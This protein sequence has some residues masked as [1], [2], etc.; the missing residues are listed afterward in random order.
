MMSALDP[1]TLPD[2]DLAAHIVLR[3]RSEEYLETA[4]DACR[5]LYLRHARGLLAFLAARV[6]SADLEDRHQAIW[7]RVWQR[8]P[9]SFRGGNFRAWLY[10]VARNYVI[11]QGQKRH[12]ESL[13]DENL[14]DRRHDLPD[15]ALLERERQLVLAR[16]LEKLEGTLAEL[17]RARLAGESYDALCQRLGLAPERAHKL[18]HQ[19]KAQLRTCVE[20]GL[21]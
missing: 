19:A 9:D 7:E 20:G 12:A 2:E 15:E 14:P 17:V 5:Q 3:G 8:L 11:D 1:G 13:V 4:R 6:R 21:P 18:F 10:K 16:C